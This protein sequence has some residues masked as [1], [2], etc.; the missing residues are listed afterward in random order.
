MTIEF[1]THDE[2]GDEIETRFLVADLAPVGVEDRED[3]PPKITGMAPPW[4]SWSEDLGFRER[5]M[6]GAFTEVLASKRLDVVLAWN[7]DESFPLARTTNQ[8]L[9]IT[10]GAKGL[11]YRGTPPDP[12]ENP[13][14]R[15]WLNLIRGR[16]VVGSSFAFTVKP[17]PAS[18][19]WA[20]DSKGNITRTIT[21]VSGLFDVSIVTRP[22]Y[23]RSTV[24]LRRRDLFAAA[25]LTEAERRQI[26]EKA[27]DAEADLVRRLAC[28]RKRIDALIGARAASA[29]AR[30]KANGF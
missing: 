21:K 28:D 7:H 25:N 14:V 29:L 13:T 8:T 17:D 4:D 24:A 3:G 16:Y 23:S 20:S 6:P 15:Q 11:E 26:A 19:Q 27:A 22:A 18:E 12:Q 2:A 5:F 9:D 1:R 10:E 30:M